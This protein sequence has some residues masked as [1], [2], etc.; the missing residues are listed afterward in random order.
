MKNLKKLLA[1][2]LSGILF[3]LAV[4][5]TYG[6]YGQYGGPAPSISVLIDKM[7]GK[8][9]TSKGGVL[10]CDSSVEFRDN[11]SPSDPRFAP[12]DT[13]CFKLVVKN[14]SNVVLQSVTVRDFLPSFVEAV[15]GP[16]SFNSGS[17]IITIAAG[18]FG[19]GEEKTFFV[20]TKV[21]PA[22]KLVN[23]NALFCL[24]NRANA[25]GVPKA[26]FA[27]NPVDEDTA[28]FCIE[29]QLKPTPTP[30]STP[31]PVVTMRVPE[32]VPSA[33][34]EMGVLLLSG[35]LLALGAGILLKKF[36]RAGL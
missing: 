10:V 14:T 24:V 13:V 18:D 33:G 20:K 21:V 23:E 15:E 19:G 25:T 27:N 36:S 29:K 35:N 30:T 34:P 4:K 16:G 7:V 32:K 11:F 3:L 28:Q 31:A 12:E 17:Q 26:D 6:Q 2:F 1:F 8:S 9:F 5:V 22:D